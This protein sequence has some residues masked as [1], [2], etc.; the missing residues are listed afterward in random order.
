MM[1]F[2]DRHDATARK[3]RITQAAAILLSTDTDDDEGFHPPNSIKYAVE[4]AVALE[5]EVTRQIE[6]ETT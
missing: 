2:W 3:G 1:N 5:K 6:E 4:I